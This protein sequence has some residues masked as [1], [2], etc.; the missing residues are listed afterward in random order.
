MFFQETYEG[1]LA[2]DLGSD[3]LLCFTA[4]HYWWLLCACVY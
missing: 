1:H 3:D 2:K 4:D